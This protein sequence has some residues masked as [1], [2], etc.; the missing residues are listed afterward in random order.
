MN[1]GEAAKA[2]GVSAKMIRHY[3]SVG[4]FPEAARSESGYR[5]YGDKEVSTLRFVRQSR[6]LGFSIEQIR[7][8]LGLWQNRRRPSRQVRALAQA[9]IEELD[10]KLKEL[11]AMK[12]TLEHLVACC[13]GDERPDCPIIDSLS[14]RPEAVPEVHTGRQKTSGLRSGRAAAR[15]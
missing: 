8:L 13:H 5:R 4:L 14:S 6:D 2:S 3:E 15:G 11:E 9:H 7:A 1:I 10:A 12:A